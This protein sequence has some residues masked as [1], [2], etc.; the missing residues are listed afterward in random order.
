MLGEQ[1]VV[2]AGL[3]IKAGRKALRAEVHQVLI[4]RLIFAQQDQVAVV[5]AARS[6]CRSRSR[7]TYTSQPMIGLD[8]RVLH[9]LL[10][11]SPPR[12]TSRRG[13]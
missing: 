7:Q 10:N 6:S 12:R 1:L 11:K 5:A 4:A 3:V 8:A 13:R 9:G 2:D